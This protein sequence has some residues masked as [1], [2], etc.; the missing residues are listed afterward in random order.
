MSPSQVPSLDTI[1]SLYFIQDFSSV[2]EWF[3]VDDKSIKSCYNGKEVKLIQKQR[4]GM[5]GELFLDKLLKFADI[6]GKC[7]I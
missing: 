1:H 4:K 3:P 6:N 5:H 2:D 7:Y